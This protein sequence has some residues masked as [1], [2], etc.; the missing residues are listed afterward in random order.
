MV[1]VRSKSS[2]HIE[3]SVIWR[4]PSLSK[5]TQIT[6]D[7]EIIHL[8]S[9]ATILMSLTSFILIKLVLWSVLKYLSLY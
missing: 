7:I 6:F 9:E 4:P 8:G 5:L 1:L 3:S 2:F